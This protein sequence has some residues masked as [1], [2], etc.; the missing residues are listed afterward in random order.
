[1]GLAD[2]EV[3]RTYLCNSCDE[4]CDVVQ[5]VSDD[6]ITTCPSCGEDALVIKSGQMNI[7]TNVDAKKS[8]TVG[9]LASRNS[10]KM[11]KE[12]TL[13]ESKWSKKKRVQSTNQA[14][15]KKLRSLGIDVK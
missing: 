3:Q 5:K 1:M 2:Q 7:R 8:R 13:P 11:E 10:E 4:T 6:W 14:A 9:M 12:G 15:L